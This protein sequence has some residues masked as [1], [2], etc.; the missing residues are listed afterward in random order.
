MLTLFSNEATAENPNK[1]LMVNISKVAMDLSKTLSDYGMA[2][3]MVATINELLPIDITELNNRMDANKK[4][5]LNLLGTDNISINN[6]ADPSRARRLMNKSENS[7]KLEKKP[8]ALSTLS[9]ITKQIQQKIDTIQQTQTKISEF[10]KL[11]Y[12]IPFWIN[13]KKEH[14]HL[15]E[16]STYNGKK[17][18]CCFTHVVGLPYKE[19]FGYL[20]WF[21]YQMNLLM[22][23]KHTRD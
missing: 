23:R 18:Y 5:A 3:P 4:K 2:P 14:A 22:P 19:G 20:P 11:L 17:G 1:Q 10:S 13:D 21:D 7:G 6:G 16:S 12:K 8:K 15:W 9:L